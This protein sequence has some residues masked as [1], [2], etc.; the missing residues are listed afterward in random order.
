MSN[1]KVQMANQFQSS[2]I[3]EFPFLAFDIHWT[4]GGF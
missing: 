4:F 3:K 1:T 2:N